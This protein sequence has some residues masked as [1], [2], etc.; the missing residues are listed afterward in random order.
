M[1]DFGFLCSGVVPNFVSHELCDPGRHC[2]EDRVR[3]GFRS[4]SDLL[5]TAPTRVT[6]FGTTLVFV[7]K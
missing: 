6:E 4:R 2:I 3:I 1:A 5:N 7:F